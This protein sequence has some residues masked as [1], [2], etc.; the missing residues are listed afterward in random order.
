M[1]RDGGPTK[2]AVVFDPQSNSWSQL[3]DIQGDKP[4]AG[5]GVSGGASTAS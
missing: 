2:A 4:L 3:A 1:N 5:F